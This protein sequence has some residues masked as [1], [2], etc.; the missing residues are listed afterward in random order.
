MAEKRKIELQILSG[1]K[2]KPFTAPVYDSY[3]SVIRDLYNQGFQSFF[4]G[5]FSTTLIQCQRSCLRYGILGPYI[6]R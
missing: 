6:Y 3:K 2:H 4:K 5:L 1:V